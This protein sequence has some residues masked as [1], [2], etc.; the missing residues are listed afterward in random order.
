MG[1]APRVI[2][3]RKGITM[4][5][6]TSR[7]T[8]SFTAFRVRGIPVRLHW[9]LLLFIPYLAFLLSAQFSTL[10]RLAG[11]QHVRL[12]LPPLVWGALLAL[13]LFASIA[14]HELA[15]TFVATRYGG[16][17]RAITLMLL[18]GVSEAVRM[19]RRPLYEG[20]MA[21]AGPATSIGLG[22]VFVL[23]DVAIGHT[24]DDVKL[25]LFYLAWMNFTLGLFNLIPAFPMDGGR[26]LRAALAGVLGRERATVIAVAIGRAFAILIGVLGLWSG[27]WLVILVA[28]FVFVGAGAELAAERIH[29]ALAGL[30]IG[31]LV[32]ALRR[33]PVTIDVDATL[34]DALARMHELDR[35]DLVAIDREGAPVSVIEA[36]DIAFVPVEARAA[37]PIED[38]VRTLPPRHVI[39]PWHAN[40]GDALEQAIEA[41]APHVVVIDDRRSTNRV[42]GS[43]SIAEIEAAAHLQA[44]EGARIPPPVA[45]AARP[46]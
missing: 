36:R 8:G 26:I 6:S 4:A 9:T 16:K 43:I 39:I 24:A 2:E 7:S 30:R 45:R 20:V 38:Y 11:M 21:L 25:G 37:V 3:I 29:G 22:L 46:T 12:H 17:V 35:L 42:V 34:A 18:G 10:E 5:T 14:I 41:G 28:A 19:P 32:P 31:D 40:V 44:I 33:A 13:G 27:N 15:H 23:L 1:S